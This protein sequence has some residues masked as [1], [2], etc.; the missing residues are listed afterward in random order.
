MR[1]SFKE[2]KEVF[3]QHCE[4]AVAKIDDALAKIPEPIVDKIIAPVLFM[5]TMSVGLGGTIGGIFG[6][7]YAIAK[8]HDS[9]LQAEGIAAASTAALTVGFRVC[10][11]INNAVAEAHRP[12][13]D[14]I[15]NLQVR[16]RS[17]YPEVRAQAIKEWKQYDL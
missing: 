17:P 3:M 14:Y 1:I 5:A 11:L 9:P 2:N 6:E 7:I 15:Y 8:F 13:P 10:S 4:T 16:C 12:H